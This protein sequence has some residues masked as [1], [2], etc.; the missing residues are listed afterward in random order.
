MRTCSYGWCADDTLQLLVGSCS[1]VLS[2]LQSTPTH[3]PAV[4]N[5]SVNG[6]PAYLTGDLFL[7]HP[8][9]PD[10]WKFYG[11][12]EDQISLANG[13]EVLFYF[14]TNGEILVTYPFLL[15]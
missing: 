5:Y 15:T 8:T 6:Q 4:I 7:K 9:E 13:E 11:R 2:K 3:T 10:L 14:R 1:F 12:V